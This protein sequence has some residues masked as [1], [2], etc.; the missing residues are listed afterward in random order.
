MQKTDCASHFGSRF[1]NSICCRI[2][3]R[4]MWGGEESQGGFNDD[5]ACSSGLLTAISHTISLD[6]SALRRKQLRI[7][8]ADAVDRSRG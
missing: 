3:I 1:L 5:T 2:E 4:S 8:A 6:Q 7:T